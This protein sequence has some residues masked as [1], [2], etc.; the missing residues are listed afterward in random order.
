MS[1]AEW[2]ESESFKTLV[3]VLFNG[4]E[5][6]DN[7]PCFYC[8][9]YQSKKGLPLTLEGMNKYMNYVAPALRNKNND[10]TE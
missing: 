10:D 5:C 9:N 3:D 6:P 8:P 2:K 4:K 1:V 7:L